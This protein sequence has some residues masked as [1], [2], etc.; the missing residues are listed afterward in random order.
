[1]SLLLP[2]APSSAAL[3]GSAAAGVSFHKP[4]II[5]RRAERKRQRRKNKKEKIGSAGEIDAAPGT[6]C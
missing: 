1:M 2:H 6:S 3:E 4:F 5:R